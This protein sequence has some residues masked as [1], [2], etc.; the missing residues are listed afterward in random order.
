M[1]FQNYINWHGP[2]HENDCPGDDTCTCKGKPINEAMENAV[3]L[4]ALKDELTEA[5]R[6]CL[7]HYC[8]GCGFGTHLDA[9]IHHFSCPMFLLLERAEGRKLKLNGEPEA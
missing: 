8:P 7:I 1:T 2:C 6:Q 9:K 5:F 4:D 3:K